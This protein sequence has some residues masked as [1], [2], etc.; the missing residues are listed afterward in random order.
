MRPS[1]RSRKRA[2]S[3]GPMPPQPSISRVVS[4]SA[5]SASAAS[6]AAVSLSHRDT[7]SLPSSSM[8]R[9]AARTASSSTRPQAVRSSDAIRGHP[10]ASATT[11]SVPTCRR[12]AQKFGGRKQSWNLLIGQQAGQVIHRQPGMPSR[13]VSSGR[14]LSFPRRQGQET[15][16]C[17]KNDTK[18]RARNLK[19]PNPP[20]NPCLLAVGQAERR[21][22]GAA[23]RQRC[24]PCPAEPSA[25]PEVQPRQRRRTRCKRRR[26]RVTMPGRARQLQRPQARGARRQRQPRKPFFSCLR[27]DR[28]S[29]YSQDHEAHSIQ[30]LT[31][32]PF[33]LA[34]LIFPTHAVLQASEG[35]EAPQKSNQRGWMPARHTGISEAACAPLSPSG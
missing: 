2:D 8:P 5:Q 3:R 21:Q 25:P 31:S 34:P 10:S 22:P 6:D 16:E 19:T 24:R 26:L 11:P 17:K 12:G 7:D 29:P 9:A 20:L 33:A 4:A 30:H 13:A 23:P 1:T 28:L 14:W 15:H 32:W 35:D 27:Q 18:K